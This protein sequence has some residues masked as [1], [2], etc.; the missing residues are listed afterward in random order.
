MADLSDVEN[1]LVDVV[2]GALYP[3]GILAPSVVGA[4]CRAYRGWP[5]SKS[6]QADLLNKVVNV[7]VYAQPGVEHNTSRFPAEWKTLTQPVP[8][9]TLALAGN[10]ITV[11]GAIQAGDVATV[12]I[13][14]RGAYSVAVQANATL[15]SIASAL[16]ALIAVDFAA[17]ATGAAITVAGSAV[18]TLATG[19]TG[20]SWME[21]RRQLKGFQVIVWASDPK[22]RD[23]VGKVIDKAFAKI[24]LGGFLALADSSAGRL[25]YIMTRE[26][27]AAQKELLY[28]RD[29]FF[30]VEYPTIDIRTDTSITAVGLNASGGASPPDAPVTTTAI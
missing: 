14:G 21:L 20:T 30:T 10:V 3:N 1:A 5:N 28:R 12:K 4:A 26:G 6:L 8:L 9:V 7:S 11:G 22:Q 16:A 23:D 17:S 2:T 18:I 27:D 25:I 15:S 24:E 29:L 19:G 13:G